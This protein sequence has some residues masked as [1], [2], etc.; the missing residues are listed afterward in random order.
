MIEIRRFDSAL[1]I[2]IEL[3]NANL[4]LITAE[5]GYVMCGYLDIKAAEKLGDSACIVT[6]VKTFDDVLE[7]RIVG[8]SSKARELGI[9]EGM[10][11]REALSL[12]ST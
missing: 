7:S 1:G 11:G 6:G 5:R 10:S 4:L 2:R 9:R 3:Q 8:V 12:L